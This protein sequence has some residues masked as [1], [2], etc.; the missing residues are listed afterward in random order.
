MKYYARQVFTETQLKTFQ[1]RDG[2]LP[3]QS[4]MN[5]VYKFL[6]YPEGVF[7]YK[8]KPMD[9]ALLGMSTVSF[10]YHTFIK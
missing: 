6:Q 8:R 3:T 5:E 1:D 9:L 2:F 10:I 4:W 7:N